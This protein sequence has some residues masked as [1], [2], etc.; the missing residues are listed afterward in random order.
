M[1][2]NALEPI[3]VCLAGQVLGIGR[4]WQE[5]RIHPWGPDLIAKYRW[6]SQ[7]FGF[8]HSLRYK[9]EKRNSSHRLGCLPVKAF[10]HIIFDTENPQHRGHVHHGAIRPGILCTWEDKSSF[11]PMSICPNPYT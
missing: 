5:P 11:S 4:R 6:L 2:E 3:C 9:V 1:C 10:L 7:I 8:V